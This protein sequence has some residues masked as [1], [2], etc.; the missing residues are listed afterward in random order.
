MNNKTIRTIRIL[1]GLAVF[2]GLIGLWYNGITPFDLSSHQSDPEQPYFNI[3]FLTMSAFCILCYAALL[4]TGIQLIRLKCNWLSVLIIVLAIEL[5]YELAVSTLWIVPDTRIS[6]SVAAATG[7]SGGGM[8][9]QLFTLFP[10]WGIFLANKMR[11]RIV[12]ES[13]N[14]SLRPTSRGS[15]PPSG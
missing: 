15:S 3:A 1:G 5:L 14:Q 10:F 6:S 11:K 8:V 4:I 13:S 2:F 9:P 7:V 12:K